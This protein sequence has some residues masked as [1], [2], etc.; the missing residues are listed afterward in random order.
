MT[1]AEQTI[2]APAATP[3]AAGQT[4]ADAHATA[5]S[6]GGVVYVV[7]PVAPFAPTECKITNQYTEGGVYAAEELDPDSLTVVLHQSLG[8]LI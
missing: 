5:W 6:W 7:P 1:N 8:Q 3:A 4:L 2:G